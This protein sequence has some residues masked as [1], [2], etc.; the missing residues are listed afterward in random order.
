MD[1]NHYEF[2]TLEN[3]HKL[4]D[5]MPTRNAVSCNVMMERYARVGY[6]EKALHILDKC[7]W[8]EW[9]QIGSPLLVF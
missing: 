7:F 6:G 4:F 9:R 2:E 3:A 5:T 8:Q 1:I